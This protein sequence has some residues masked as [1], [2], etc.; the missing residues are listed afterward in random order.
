MG[1]PRGLPGRGL[2][3]ARLDGGD[4]LRA[5]MLSLSEGHGPAGGVPMNCTLSS[6]GGSCSSLA[7]DGSGGQLAA[8][9]S[10][11]SGAVISG[12]ASTP[13]PRFGAAIALFGNGSSSF[14]VLLFGGV[15]FNGEVLNDTWQFDESTL[16]WWNVTPYLHC[17]PTTCPTGRSNALA[18]WDV[19]DNEVVMFGGC[20]VSPPGWTGNTPGCPLISKDISNQTW[21]YADPNGGVGAWATHGGV[22]PPGRFSGGIAA[23]CTLGG[24]CET[25]PGGV[26]FG[27]VLI[28]GGCGAVCPLG[29]TWNFFHGVW[30]L[31]AG[32]AP[33]PRY[34][35]AMAISDYSPPLYAVISLFGG[36]TSSQA[37]CNNGL[38]TTN[39]TWD[40]NGTGWNRVYSSSQCAHSIG[41]CPPARY[42][43][44]STSY[45]GP[46]LP[47]DLE[48]F[49]GAGQNGTI[50]GSNLA[51]GG[52]WWTFNP[53]IPLW[54]PKPVP[55]GLISFS[56]LYPVGPAVARYDPMLVGTDL[57]GA[58]LFG[59]LSRS[60]SAL[61]D[62]WFASTSHPW[63]V[64][65]PPPTP[66]P[67]Y[68]GTMV[69]A[70][71]MNRSVLFGGCGAEC[72]NRTTWENVGR[73]TTQ[74]WISLWPTV[75]STNSPSG[76]YGASMVYFAG[77]STVL[78]FGGAES[79]GTL[80]NDLWGFTPPQGWKR[81]SVSGSTPSPREDAS[82]AYSTVTNAAVLFGG[83]D[84]STPLGDTYLLFKG[85]STNYTWL[86][87]PLSP[88]PSARGEASMAYDGSSN[89]ATLFGGLGSSGLLGDT[90][91]FSFSLRSWSQ[92][93]SSGCTG[94]SAPSARWGASMTYDAAT[95][96]DI[97]FGGCGSLCPLADTWS[98]NS[99]GWSHLNVGGS[100]PPLYDAPMTYNS[101]GNYV[102]L[103]GGVSNDG[104]VSG[105]TWTFQGLSWSP[106]PVS[107]PYPLPLQ[108]G[109]R[110][111]LSMA[112]NSTGGYVLLVGGCQN[113][114]E[115]S[116]GT[117][118][119]GTDTWEFV[120]GTWDLICVSC[121]PS[122]RWG[123]SLAYD[124]ASNEFI[125]VGGCSDAQVVCSP[126][127]VLDDVW[128]FGDGQWSKLTTPPFQ[129]RG[130]AS[131]A[132]DARDGVLVLFGGIGCGNVCGDTWEFLAGGWTMVSSSVTPS[133]RYGAAMAYDPNSSEERLLLA[134]GMT[135]GGVALDDYWFFS[136]PQG[137]ILGASSSP[138]SPR[139]NAAMT[140]DPTIGGM[141]MMGGQGGAQLV[142]PGVWEFTTYWNRVGT[143]PSGAARWGLGL[144]YDPTAGV[145]G[146]VLLFGGSFISGVSLA[147]VGQ[148]DTWSISS[149][150]LNPLLVPP[151]SSLIIWNDL[152]LDV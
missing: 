95:Q 143:L 116:C 2:L 43:M 68:D 1:A 44:S 75:N 103:Q 117:L 49:G 50:F 60:G 128:R 81:E 90:W 12:G 52:G 19:S 41:L 120:N 69:Y 144:E 25:G 40:F 22:E 115:G 33:T 39:G 23:F 29:D 125:L 21:T 100:P 140:Y 76:R 98:Y 145:A 121:G 97:L 15:S 56:S 18:T 61:G 14:G 47:W 55:L 92:C 96:S 4:L 57:D 107:N 11:G 132:Y 10:P 74:P 151:G 58:L 118:S 71:L 45:Q 16:T 127:T 93:T 106:E 30:T 108:P 6:G 139:A 32:P 5:A 135:A 147:M 110:L 131:M 138:W 66:S 54:V 111:G 94:S 28:F 7:L 133:P 20:L 70:S 83:F 72:G 46:G 141:L 105:V 17:S 27:G 51:N 34:G 42:L 64:I 31:K 137:W 84:G 149:R 91:G 35:V 134:G 79:N 136:L 73:T 114:G 150:L 126:G 148:G 53:A 104:I 13:S 62:T 102:L 77:T 63:T 101:S 129:G 59:G 88:S 37:G 3:L 113:L 112:Y 142:R 82:V 124:G 65:N 123:A 86:R 9:G 67:E 109:A 38:D 87:L 152:T 78:L 89:S 85:S 26:P 130:M 36:C 80:L 48:L 24:T 8:A 99:G 119:Q 146:Y 122:G